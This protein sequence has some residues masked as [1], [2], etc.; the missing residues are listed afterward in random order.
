MKSEFKEST[1][2]NVRFDEAKRIRVKY[3]DRIPCVLENH[4]SSSLPKSDKKKF[5]IPTSLTMGQFIY[6]VRKR[7]K[8]S[9]EKAIFIF[10]GE[11][12]TLVSSSMVLSNVYQEHKSEDGFLYFI[13]NDENTFGF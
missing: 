8:I 4:H 13:M 2:F 12:S 7:I 3:P 9:P 10:V 5:L 6:V 11:T 1:S